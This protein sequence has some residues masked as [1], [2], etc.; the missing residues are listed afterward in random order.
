MPFLLQIKNITAW[1][2]LLTA[3]FVFVLC[4]ATTSCFFK[5]RHFTQHEITFCLCWYSLWQ[6]E[7]EKTGIAKLLVVILS[8]LSARH[9]PFPVCLNMFFS[10]LFHSFEKISFMF[11]CN[12][13]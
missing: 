9:F 13:I 6:I 10:V 7:R 5:V 3:L 8:M 12:H 4:E 11:V 2:V 1:A